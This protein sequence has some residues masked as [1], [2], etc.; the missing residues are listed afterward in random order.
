VLLSANCL[1]RT[2]YLGKADHKTELLIVNDARINL[3]KTTFN[4][5]YK[6]M[7]MLLIQLTLL[8]NAGK[9]G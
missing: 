4:C 9:K 6:S 7:N 5:S 2:K 3:N 1:K 8:L